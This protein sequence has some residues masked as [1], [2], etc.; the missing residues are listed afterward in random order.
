MN[1]I[2]VK[3]LKDGIY[4]TDDVYLDQNFLLLTKEIPVTNAFIKALM[5][6]EVKSVYSEGELTDTEVTEPAESEEIT[7]EL[8]K[9][10]LQIC[11]NRLQPLQRQK[12]FKSTGNFR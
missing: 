10:S 11:G 6:W 3:E 9:D 1:A 4:F 8:E 5:D 7:R 2:P 12:E